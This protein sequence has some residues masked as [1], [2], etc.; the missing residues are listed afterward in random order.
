MKKYSNSMMCMLRIIL[1]DVMELLLVCY[2]LCA[3]TPGIK[4]LNA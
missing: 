1:T 3:V 4:Y 2:A